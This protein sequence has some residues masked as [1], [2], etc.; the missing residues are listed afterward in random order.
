ML[1][2]VAAVFEIGFALG[3]KWTQGF[4]RP[5]PV[6]VTL[7]LAMISLLLLTRSLLV[8]PVGTAYAAW[9][10]IGAVGTAILGMLVFGEPVT[11]GRVA[12]LGCVILGVIGLRYFSAGEAPGRG[13][14]PAT[15]HAQVASRRSADPP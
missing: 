13:E 10:G 2:L 5:I 7:V 3:M 4:S 11:P 8:L 9:T 15:P 12:S 14:P 1:L 6:V